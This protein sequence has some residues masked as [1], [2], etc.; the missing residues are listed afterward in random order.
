M[1]E[2]YKYDFVGGWVRINVDDPVYDS[3]PPTASVRIHQHGHTYTEDFV[4]D[5]SSED[6][7]R[8]YAAAIVVNLIKFG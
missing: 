2:N 7:A 6:E 4:Q 1:P 5:Y 8:K 3:C